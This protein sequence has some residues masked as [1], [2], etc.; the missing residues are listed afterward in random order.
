MVALVETGR[1]M[2]RARKIEGLSAVDGAVFGL[3]G[4]LM[5]FTFGSAAAR[6]ETRRDLIVE[7][8]N[9]IGTAYLRLDLLPA[10]QQPSLRDA[11]R[12]YVDVRLALYRKVA[13][14]ES[15]KAE[16]ARMTDL[17]KEIWEGA[18]AACRESGSQPATMLLLPALNAM[19]DITTVRTVALQTHQ[20]TVIFVMLALMMLACSLLAGFGMAGGTQ[21]SW[22]HVVCF[23]AVL[24][25]AFY[26]ILDLEYPRIG[27]IRIDWM[28]QIFRDLRSSMG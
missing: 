20:P 18:V 17:Q 19:I 4:L 24:T 5:A 27:L 21:R 8:A 10:A 15:A 23:A 11:F 25:I 1:R 26:V 3:M 13:D 12:R 2:G 7:E 14:L 22:L 16:L 6:F 28:D 9:D